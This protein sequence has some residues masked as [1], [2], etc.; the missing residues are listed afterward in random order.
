MTVGPR[1]ARAL[2][3]LRVALSSIGTIDLAQIALL[4]GRVTRPPLLRPCSS[5]R[6]RASCTGRRRTDSGAAS[7]RAR[8]TRAPGA[9][10][11][12]RRQGQLRRRRIHKFGPGPIS[13]LFLV[14]YKSQVS[15]VESIGHGGHLLHADALPM[16][17]TVV[18]AAE[19][20]AHLPKS[21]THTCRSPSLYCTCPCPST[22]GACAF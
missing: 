8:T 15:R 3:R 18:Q 2:A 19:A 16:S 22:A 7:T 4:A 9:G 17:R 12:P 21:R 13:Q 14:L 11:V 6:R 20:L 5:S 10:P 1:P